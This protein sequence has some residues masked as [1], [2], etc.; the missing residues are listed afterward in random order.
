MA[1][2]AL[3]EQ[4]FK[5]KV[6]RA[7]LYPLWQLTT[8]HQTG[9][10]KKITPCQWSW[11]DLQVLIDDAIA[12]TTLSNAERR[13]LLMGNPNYPDP[14]L[15]PYTTPALQS[16]IQTLMPGESARPHRHTPNALRFVLEDGGET[17][18]VVDGK[19]CRMERRDVV[20]TPAYT[21]HGHHHNGETRSV[22]LD[23][24][25]SQLASYLDAGFFEPGI[26]ME[27]NVPDTVADA[28]FAEPGYAPVF[29]DTVTR[30]YSPRYHYS[31]H[32]TVSALDAT[33]IQSDGS[34]TVILTN[35]A[36]GGPAMDRMDCRMTRIS[37]R[38][39]RRMRTT[40]P[41]IC[42]AAAGS[43]KTRIGDSELC[44][45]EN[46]IF[47]LPHWSWTSHQADGDNATLFIVSDR[48]VQASL[49]LLRE[50]FAD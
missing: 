24:L 28:I 33:P 36:T 47:T 38:P 18:T 6:N 34:A 46:D 11:S 3:D 15:T 13:V 16:G 1:S 40:A 14:H 37:D 44:W 20:L 30:D 49:G 32:D 29:S 4:S 9:E 42:V 17:F 26:K 31:W 45:K 2:A 25:D 27:G 8:L 10:P 5:T 41:A 21:W 43:G 39:T 22:W 7:H 48:A 12:E 35:P 19:P 50:E 23:V